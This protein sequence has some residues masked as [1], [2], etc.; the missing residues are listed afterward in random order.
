MR[1]RPTTRGQRWPIR[2]Q[3]FD[4][5]PHIKRWGDY[6]GFLDKEAAL[7]FATL[8]AKQ[9]T[10]RGDTIN[11]RVREGRRTI[12]LLEG[13]S[14][15][16]RENQL[17]PFVAQTR[18]DAA[19]IERNRLVRLLQQADGS[20]A[21]AATLAGIDRTNFR[22]TLHRHGIDPNEELRQGVAKLREAFQRV[23]RIALRWMHKEPAAGDDRAEL[24]RLTL[25]LGDLGSPTTSDA[26]KKGAETHVG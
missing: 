24:E 14:G 26:L 10:A 4:D 13:G 20:V 9:A 3:T 7:D 11:V 1:G 16:T 2:V 15:A 21:G 18:A 6:R 5:R 23:M 22:R 17:S 19:Q 25:E 8:I 12:F